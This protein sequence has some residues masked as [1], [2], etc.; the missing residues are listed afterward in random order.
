[1][2]KIINNLNIQS[3]LVNPYMRLSG[4]LL[5]GQ[6]F[7]TPKFFIIPLH[8]SVRK[9][10]KKLVLLRHVEIRQKCRKCREQNWCRNVEKCREQNVATF[11]HVVFE[12]VENCRNFDNNCCGYFHLILIHFC[13][14]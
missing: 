3:N 10:Q 8:V 7:S 6:N 1:M 13:I 2:F 12:Y 9:C 14:L 5:F 11:R 4:N